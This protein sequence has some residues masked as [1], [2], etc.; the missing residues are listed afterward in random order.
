MNGGRGIAEPRGLRIVGSCSSGSLN[1][2]LVRSLSAYSPPGF[3]PKPGWC[4]I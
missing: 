2:W 4:Q 3:D 1:E